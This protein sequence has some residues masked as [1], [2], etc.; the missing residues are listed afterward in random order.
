MDRYFA[1][2]I[3]FFFQILCG[4]NVMVNNKNI[5]NVSSIEFYNLYTPSQIVLLTNVEARPQ[6]IVVVYCVML[7]AP[8]FL[9]NCIIVCSVD[10]TK[11]KQLNMLAGHMFSN[12]QSIHHALF[13][14]AL[15]WIL[16]RNSL[17]APTSRKNSTAENYV[18][19]APF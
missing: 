10:I 4:R 14:F 13:R 8:F 3:I 5:N 17:M 7:I 9:Y 12:F 19:R 1:V 16:L 11:N 15:P 6:V 2:D 18:K